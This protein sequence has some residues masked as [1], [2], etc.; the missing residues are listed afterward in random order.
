MP[1]KR[2][3]KFGMLIV[4]FLEILCNHLIVYTV[5]RFRVNKSVDQRSRQ[6][7]KNEIYFSA[8]LVSFSR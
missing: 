2:H 3:T 8:R 6:P 1:F 7:R 4:T 5:F